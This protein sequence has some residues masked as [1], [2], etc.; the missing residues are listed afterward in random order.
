MNSRAGFLKVEHICMLALILVQSLDAGPVLQHPAG[1]SC[2]PRELTVLSKGLVEESIIRFEKAN[3][4]HLGTWSPGF[5][6]LEV[7]KNSSLNGP[8]AQCS[9]LFM[10]KGLE[11]VLQDQKTNLNP[12]DLPLH[13][14]L[15]EA[16]SRVNMLAGCVK[17]ILGGECS[18]KPSPPTMPKHVF[19]RKQWSHT[20]LKSARDYLNWMEGKFEVQISVSQA[21]SVLKRTASRATAKGKNQAARKITPRK[22]YFEGSG[23]FL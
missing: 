5:P 4:K 13:Q 19:E 16:I 15:K 1:V 9:L 20:L 7:H 18:P 3:G 10:V 11:K 6:E 21:K 12:E 14:K 2:R 23:Y 8:E 17:E 22:N